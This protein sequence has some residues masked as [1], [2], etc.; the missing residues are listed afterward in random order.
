MSEGQVMFERRYVWEPVV[1]VYHWINVLCMFVL[2][3]TGFYIGTPF[4]NVTGLP[5]PYFTATARFTHYVAATILGLVVIVRFYWAFVGNRYAQWE[6]VLP[7]N[8]ERGRDLW[9]QFKYYTFLASQRPSYVGHNP[10]AGITYAGLWVLTVIQGITGLA[11]N[12]EVNPGGFWWTWFGWAFGVSA[13]QTLRL[14]HH[15][16]MW[17]FIVFFLVHLY[18]AI[19]DDVEE[20]DGILSSIINGVK[21]PHSTPSVEDEIA[22]RRAGNARS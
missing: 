1:R 22:Q 11:L 13:N 15:S 4:V 19:L 8:Q 18:M 12:A 20:R 3:T 10:I 2:A 9:K 14:I 17:V 21:W 5:F 16:L 6:G 7:L